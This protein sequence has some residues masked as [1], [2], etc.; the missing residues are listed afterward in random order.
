[1]NSTISTEYDVDE[2]IAK[3][4]NIPRYG[5]I[6]KVRKFKHINLLE[7]EIKWLCVKAKDIVAEQPVFL[8]LSSPIN[9]CGKNF[10]KLISCL[11]IF[12]ILI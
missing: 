1:M 11:N 7:N 5:L 9:I 10:N 12:Y 4:M 2:I 8:E 6:L 3:L